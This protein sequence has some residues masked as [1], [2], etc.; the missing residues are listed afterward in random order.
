MNNQQIK[1]TQPRLSGVLRA[2]IPDNATANPNLPFMKRQPWLVVLLTMMFAR[3]ALAQP[4][5]QTLVTSGLA[6]P[7][8]VAVDAKNNYYVTDSA[9]NRIAKYDPNSGVLTNLAGVFGEIGRNDGPGVFAHFFSPQGI[10]AAR[11]GMV[12]A[13]SGNHLIRFVALDGTV[14]TI[15]GSTFG[16]N[17]GAG[18]AA[19]FN[20]PAGLAADAAGNIYVADLANNRIRKID[21]A[22]NVTTL[23]G[24]F[25]RPEAV[26]VDKATG[27]I[28]VADT[29]NHSIALIKPDNSVTVVAGS[30]SRFISGKQ[31][32]LI[33][34]SASF[35]SPRGL[36][37]V[38]GK[39]GLLV[40]DTGNSLVRRVYFNTNFNTFS[41][42]TYMSSPS[43]NAP[44]GIALDNIG[45]F[46]LVDLGADKL[47]IVQVT[48]PQPPVSNPQIGVVILTTNA[49]GQLRTELVP[50]VNSTFNNDVNVAILAE[51][52]T[53][54]FYTLNPDAEFPEDVSSRGTPQPYV[55]GLL[56]WPFTLI[57]PRVDGSN[58][59]IR[60][61][62]TQDGRRSSAIVTAR[63]QFKT[64]GPVINGKNPGGFTMDN[65]TED[66][67]L[68]YTTDGSAPTNDA[69][70][71]LYIPG[72][73]LNI[74][75]GTN[76]IVFKVRAFK[77]G[78][79]PSPEVVRTFL[80]SDLE[81]SSIGVTR[82]F[83]AGIGSTIVVPV[84][85]KL[86]TDD[87]LHSLQF[88]VEITPDDG[89]PPVSTQF[90]YLHISTND[91]LS[92]P[93]VSNELPKVDSYTTDNT[94]GLA[95]SFI[96]NSALFPAILP[97]QSRADLEAEEIATVALLAV[98]IPPSAQVGQ[99]YTIGIRFPSGTSDGR[100]T[101]INLVTFPDRK[102]TVTNIS[103]VVGDSAIAGWYNAGNFGNGN[104]NNNDVNNAFLAS[105]GVFTPYP[106]SDV[107]DAM[108]AFPEDTS[109]SV[110]GDGQIRFLDWNVISE[111]SLRLS[112]NNWS[113]SWSDG[114]AR[115]ATGASLNGAA[116]T[117][118]E[119]FSNVAKLAWS[120][121][122][123][124]SAQTVENLVPGQ[125]VTVP[126]HGRMAN[127]KQIKG[128]QFRA[129]V[130]PDADAPVLEQ[131]VQFLANP[132]LPSPVSLQGLDSRMPLNQTIGAWSLTQNAFARP[133][134]DNT[135]LGH[136]SF[137]VPATAKPGQSYTVRF[138]NVDGSP[139]LRT[140]YDFESFPGTVWVGTAAQRSAEILSD[141][142][143]Q[144]FFGS[145]NN[146]FSAPDA[147]P[148]GDGVSNLRAYKA[149]EQPTKLRLHNLDSAWRDSGDFKLRWFA[150][151]GCKYI[152]ERSHDLTKWTKIAADIS[153][154]GGVMEVTDSK[155][156]GTT[157]FYRVRF[158]Q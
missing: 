21:L 148:D 153:G 90:R 3:A 61:I 107:F 48:G 141:E 120:R 50:I 41:V 17:D 59:V 137:K 131:H 114:G 116:S 97:E 151:T 70:S 157:Y 102:V 76:D 119:S 45:N 89:A 103:Y 105:L 18:T 132:A 87:I 23:P 150:E 16:F 24:T 91:F 155:A 100:Q 136:I 156:A 20:A 72:T 124:V 112:E 36:L 101:P 145:L 63:F 6:E 109:V 158:Q 139:D 38:G 67:Q 75:S 2:R 96:S 47:M 94:T 135:L 33:A 29:G 25:S 42:E 86:A 77:P 40:S 92:L 43:L 65:A 5:L 108:D 64:A 15:A 22:N 68:W 93:V 79:T 127:G 129:T 85:V 99:T 7:Y 35:A 126:V 83:N 133:I 140:Q 30:G 128:L 44:V 49:F 98:P 81:N 32:S 95:I 143:K 66:A 113:R 134:T 121:D 115:A 104:L 147:D 1:Q 111:R 71:R 19:Q 56:D 110:G 53:D 14:T 31:D 37:W 4:S 55:N 130:N 106:F 149:G 154:D 88:R 62:S 46:P 146:P 152:V 84:D 74:V 26:T 60:A 54:T 27:S 10:V 78:Y 12:V 142:W 52:G 82:D 8:G 13:D 144:R 80:Y 34:T 58:V 9:H 73:R 122:G 118:A 117:P 69:P 51:G 28:Y 138:S 125:T 123:S 39:T 11:G 57:T